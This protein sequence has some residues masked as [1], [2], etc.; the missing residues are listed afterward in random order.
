MNTFV[1][2]N[3]VIAYL[4]KA[5]SLLTPTQCLLLRQLRIWFLSLWISLHFLKFCINEIVQY[6]LLFSIL[7]F[8]KFVYEKKKK[9]VYEREWESTSRGGAQGEGKGEGEEENLRQTPL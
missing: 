7:F 8:L 2:S 4:P 6:E 9:F 3:S 5:P 1:T